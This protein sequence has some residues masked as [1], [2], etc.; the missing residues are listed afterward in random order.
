M[1]VA[2]LPVP[3]ISISPAP[4]QD[5]LDD[6]HA[7]ALSW[8][9]MPE[10]EDGFRAKL[11]TPPPDVNTFGRRISP[12]AN[13]PKGNGIDSERFQSMLKATRERAAPVISKPADLR[14]E[15][16][17]RAHKNKQIERRALFLSKVMAPPSPTA[18]SLP[19]TP[20]ES[21]AVFHYTLPSP[22]L[23]S[24]LAL[25]D[26]L[27]NDESGMGH[28]SYPRET[29][30]EQV[31]FRSV[32]PVKES[33]AP[34]LV[35]EPPTPR[36]MPSLAEISARIQRQGPT[37]ILEPAPRVS[38]LPAFLA[39]QPA[40]PAKAARP[41][42]SVGR[43][44]MP[45]HSKRHSMPAMP[46]APMFDDE[47]TT[48]PIPTIKITTTRVPHMRRHS[49]PHELSESNVFAFNG[50]H[51]AKDTLHREQTAKEML[52][53]LRRRMQPI[54]EEQDRKFRRHSAPADFSLGRPRSGFE[55]PVLL[56]PGGF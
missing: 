27:N 46:A 26:A 28:L 21:P 18:T 47:L 4:P 16:A 14:K 44:Q 15:V 49:A 56:L 7:L 11:L 43:L 30:I 42:L 29:W 38:R 13:K 31:D 22:G 41:T 48:P 24:P 33:I 35:N 6:A 23:V 45:V 50:K 37:V 36:S 54:P 52:S 39:A 40:Q 19:K 1:A 32:T 9:A 5:I 51:A 2:V 3:Q 34:S 8:P 10:D 25:F 20:P 53:T 12:L 17:I 55:H